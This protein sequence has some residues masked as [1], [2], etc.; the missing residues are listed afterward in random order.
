M[1]RAKA[2]QY[3]KS[4]VGMPARLWQVL[5]QWAKDERRSASATIA[6]LIEQEENRRALAKQ[7]SQEAKDA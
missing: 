4:S 5:R 6:L 1:K 7:A 2:S 3:E